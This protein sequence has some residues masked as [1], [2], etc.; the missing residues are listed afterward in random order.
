MRR[1]SRASRWP[2]DLVAHALLLIALLVAIV[3]AIACVP[4]GAPRLLAPLLIV[5][6]VIAMGVTVGVGVR[7][8]SLRASRAVPPPAR[9]VPRFCTVPRLGRPESVDPGI[10]EPPARE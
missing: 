10:L 1:R 4:V 9:A 8:R 2:L 7:R 5:V 6:Y 3:V